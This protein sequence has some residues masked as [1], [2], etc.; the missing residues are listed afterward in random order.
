MS[1]P[2]APRLLPLAALTAT[3]LAATTRGVAQTAPPPASAPVNVN[4]NV[5]VNDPDA[6]KAA[7]SQ[8]TRSP[9]SAPPEVLHVPTLERHVEQGILRPVPLS[10]TLPRDIALR[11]RRVL[12]HYRLWG[13]P[14]WITLE[15]GRTGA[16][17]V[18]AVPCR[19]VSTVTGDLKYYI[20]VRDAAG[21]VLATGASRARPY[22]VTIKNDALLAAGAPRVAKCPDPADCP[23]G[24]PGCGI[25]P[26]ALSERMRAR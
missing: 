14:D 26:N 15:L 20:R 9:S 8:S 22:R 4:V 3:L 11:A 24:L 17:F 16:R 2:L 18:G 5:N 7:P 10:V 25:V 1:A 19:E 23:A 6:A 13:D 21:R 12:V